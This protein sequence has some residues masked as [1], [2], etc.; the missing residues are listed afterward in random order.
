MVPCLGCL[1]CLAAPLFLVCCAHPRPSWCGSGILCVWVAPPPVCWCFGVPLLCTHSCPTRL[2]PCMRSSHL[3][4][5]LTV[6]CAV[7]WSRPCCHPHGG[8]LLARHCGVRGHL[9]EGRGGLFADGSPGMRR[10]WWW[11]LCSH[12][13]V[14]LCIAVRFS[15]A[16]WVAPGAPGTSAH[17]S[18]SAN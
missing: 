5:T 9:V 7:G 8:H 13:M 12:L 11:L 14:S 17:A 10:I 1:S 6:P 16:I 4:M 3:C 2:P 18:K 15:T